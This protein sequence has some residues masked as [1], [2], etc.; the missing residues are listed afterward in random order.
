MGQNLIP[1]ARFLIPAAFTTVILIALVVSNSARVRA[2]EG[3]TPETPT[4]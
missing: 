4:R 1:I 2:A 3:K